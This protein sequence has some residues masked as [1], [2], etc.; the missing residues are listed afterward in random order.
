MCRQAKSASASDPYSTKTDRHDDGAGLEYDRA[1]L[2]GDLDRGVSDGAA[3]ALNPGRR[4]FPLSAPAECRPTTA[5]SA[6]ASGLGNLIRLT[7]VESNNGNPARLGVGDDHSSVGDGKGEAGVI[8]AA[9]LA[10][11]ISC[12][13]LACLIS[14]RIRRFI[15]DTHGSLL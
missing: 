9:V 14:C 5:S 13:I 12:K 11:L 4:E 3:A 10:C 2:I 15:V 8:C 7:A 1:A 6:G